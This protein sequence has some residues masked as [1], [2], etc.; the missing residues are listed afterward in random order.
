MPREIRI[1]PD[2][3]MVAIRSDEPE[4]AWDAWGV[5]HYR[6]GGHWRY[7]ADVADWEVISA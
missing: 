1:S 7:G 3:E 6:R 2:G 4:T 5:M